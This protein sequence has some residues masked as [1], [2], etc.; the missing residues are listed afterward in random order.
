ML[1]KYKKFEYKEGKIANIIFSLSYEEN[2]TLYLDYLKSDN[3]RTLE[4]TEELFKKIRVSIF[5]AIELFSNYDIIFINSLKYGETKTKIILLVLE[6]ITTNK[7]VIVFS[8]EKMTC[9]FLTHMKFESYYPFE[10]SNV[11]KLGKLRAFFSLYKNK[12]KTKIAEINNLLD[13]YDKY[14]E[15][16][17]KAKNKKKQIKEISNKKTPPLKSYY[18]ELLFVFLFTILTTI[19]S[20][21]AFSNIRV[22][23]YNSAISAAVSQVRRDSNENHIVATLNS[24]TNYSKNVEFFEELYLKTG[25]FISYLT[26]ST[27]LKH[28]SSDL[29]FN[30]ILFPNQTIDSPIISKTKLQF[31]NSSGLETVPLNYNRVIISARVLEKIFKDNTQTDPNNYIGLTFSASYN[32]QEIDFIVDNI[33]INDTSTDLENYHENTFIIFNKLSQSDNSST[34]TTSLIKNNIKTL[35]TYL[36]EFYNNFL[37]SDF[38]DFSYLNKKGEL[39]TDLFVLNQITPYLVDKSDKL[40]IEISFIIILLTISYFLIKIIL[41]LQKIYSLSAKELLIINSTLIVSVVTVYLTML[42][43][44]LNITPSVV[45]FSLFNLFGIIFST[46]LVFIISVLIWHTFLLNFFRSKLS[47]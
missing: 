47:H 31:L 42:T 32:F 23:S 9:S 29:D 43:I 10:K 28:T 11:Q 5:E 16:S 38:L 22:V 45:I 34:R 2:I 13:E 30:P 7:M 41:T 46:S 37:E 3:Y 25:D 27:S 24:S 20:V 44:R 26:F 18:L 8:S 35:D 36:E 6:Q 19:S 15:E 39:I 4:I 17:K 21:F 12:V 40:T 1:D 33:I 14:V